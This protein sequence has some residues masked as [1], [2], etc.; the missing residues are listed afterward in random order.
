MAATAS[1]VHASET[2]LY[3]V[4]LQLVVIVIAARIV[5]PVAVRIGQNSAVGE[6]VIGLLLGPSLFGVVAPDAFQYVFRSVPATPLTILSQ[7]GLILLMFQI[8]LEFDFGH[9]TDRRNRKVVWGVAIAGLAMPFALG[10]GFGQWVAP[11]LSPSADPVASALFVATAFSITALPI[12]GRILI[13]LGLARTPLGVI[14][15]S[16]AAI[17]DVV[18]W[19]LLAMVTAITVADFSAVGFVKVAL[20]GVFFAVAWFA[21]RPVLRAANRRLSTSADPLPHAL[22]GIVLAAIFV[23]AMTTYQLGIFAIFGGFA[24]G[25]ILHQE[26]GMVRPGTSASAPSCWCS[27]C[28]SSSRSRVFAPTSAASRARPTGAGA[29]G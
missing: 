18:G 28:R 22:I 24:M 4:L 20:V 25:V 8:G 29:Q 9:L 26:R 16:A 13:D 1:S 23:G 11:I 19:L 6:I 2:L 7:I 27:S 14:A 10:F 15:I 12:L 17:N 3:F 21:V 5:G